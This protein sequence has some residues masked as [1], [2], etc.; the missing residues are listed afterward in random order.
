[1]KRNP[2]IPFGVTAVLGIIL[3]VI[4]SIYGSFQQDQKAEQPQEGKQ[5][6]AEPEEIYSQNSCIQCHGENLEGGSGGPS[7]KN[8]GSDMSKDE[9]LTQILEGGGGMPGGIIQGKQ[10]EKVAQ[11]LSEMK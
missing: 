6:A 9:I 2:L 5:T 3:V 8:V 1:M 10:A 11:W 7:L 4:L